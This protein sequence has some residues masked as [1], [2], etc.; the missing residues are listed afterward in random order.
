VKE[1]TNH[2][3]PR[4]DAQG[5]SS[6]FEAQTY[7]YARA[8]AQRSRRDFLRQAGVGLGA[9][10]LAL[11]AG[12]PRL[13]AQT[14]GGTLRIA[15][16]QESDTLDPHKTTLLVA[17]EVCWQIY[18]PLIYLDEAG[19]VYP[20][21]ALSWA[22]SNDNKTVTFKLRPDI[23]FHDGTPFNA[24]AVKFTVD[25]HL[26]A[27][28]ASPTSWI[29][30]PIDKV[31]VVDPMTVAYHYKDPFIA[32]W[33]GLGYSY[34][35]PISPAAVAKFG[36]QYGRNPVGT[37]PFKFVSWEPDQGITL[38][39][40][41]EHTWATPMYANQGAAHLEGATYVVIPEDATRIAALMSG[42]VDLVSGTDSVPVDKLKQLEKTEGIKTYTR[43]AVGL[44]YSYINTKIKPLDDV[45]VR[46]AM[47]YALDKK[48]MIT[49]VLDG[50]GKPAYSPVG[51]A[52]AD[53]EPAVEKIGYDY[54]LDK[55]KAL[56]K[57]A[58]QEAGFTID[59]LVIENPVYRRLAEVIQQD[60]E[61]INI[62]LNIQAYP[63]GELFAMAPKGEA[64]LVFFYY[65]YSDPD[66]IYALLKTGQAMSWTFI[67][68]PEL[69][70]LLDEQR[71][72]FDPAKRKEM[73]SKIQKIAVEDAHWLYLY[74]G[75]Y[76]AAFRENVKGLVLD[77]VGFHHLQELSIEG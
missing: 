38:E 55:A 21:L 20:A 50:F 48:K 17:H 25:R 63:V 8:W 7:A 60:F 2:Q 47:N 45:R 56:M 49:L 4:D 12:M 65:T 5:D 44:Y 61:K 37:G 76:A 24:D 15:R 34:C 66:L 33:V 68:N 39:R 28:T 59:Y 31:E 73:L 13:R 29:L 75:I 18:D 26:D 36:D 42:D 72:E 14:E 77:T 41:A 22:F 6:T 3:A 23:K 71:I 52:F 11:A 19:K 67:N 10:G 35:A 1:S 51:T 32:L 54:D 40:N 74:E 46:K 27:K 30:G 43:P 16:G 62:K 9:A 53:Y 70:K 58:G 57:E 64:G 69:D